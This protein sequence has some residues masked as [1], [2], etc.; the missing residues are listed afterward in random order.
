M[1]RPSKIK[2]TKNISENRATTKMAWVFGLL[3]FICFIWYATETSAICSGE[4]CGFRGILP[5][6]GVM[7]FGL[8]LFICILIKLGIRF[9]VTRD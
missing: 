9:G 8:I 1:N 2:S 7:I 5:I 4:F 3:T 6:F